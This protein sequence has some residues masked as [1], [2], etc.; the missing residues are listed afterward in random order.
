MPRALKRKLCCDNCRYFNGEIDGGGA[1]GTCEV[2]PPVL[3]HPELVDWDIQDSRISL[4]DWWRQPVV[5]VD[6][7][8]RL[9]EL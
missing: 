3:V 1:Y 5:S 9:H 2:S 7:K 6:S 4:M 8:C